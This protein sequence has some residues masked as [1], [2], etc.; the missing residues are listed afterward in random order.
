MTQKRNGQPIG[1]DPYRATL[2]PRR[3]AIGSVAHSGGAGEEG[4]VFDNVI[5]I[6]CCEPKRDRRLDSTAP[7]PVQ[8]R[9]NASIEARPVQ[10]QTPVA[11]SRAPAVPSAAAACLVPD[12]DDEGPS[13]ANSARASSPRARERRVH[14]VRATDTRPLAL[15][16]EDPNVLLEYC[17]SLRTAR[18]PRAS[19]VPRSPRPGI[20]SPMPPGRFAHSYPSSPEAP[21]LGGNIT[22][23]MP[24]AGF[25]QPQTVP[26]VPAG[27]YMPQSAP[28]RA[29]RNMYAQAA[30]SYRSAQ[31]AGNVRASA[32]RQWDSL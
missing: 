17:K 26:A 3:R 27:G 11:P 30:M 9:G 19:A 25:S 12:P 2:P 29:E 6:L 32:L 21:L 4:S 8:P 31:T 10:A 5:A 20:A 16:G 14:A 13:A 18:E 7:A 22:P 15:R 23:P 28:L 1:A 24:G